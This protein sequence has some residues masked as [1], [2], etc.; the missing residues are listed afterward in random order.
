MD[1]APLVDTLRELVPGASFDV[2]P[3]IDMPTVYVDVDHLVDVCR[4]LRDAPSLQFAFLADV[5]AVD[6][7]PREP[8]FEVVYHL[9]CLGSAYAQSGGAAPARRLRLKVRVAGDRARLPSVTAVY[10]TA[11]WPEREVFDLFGLVFDGHADLRR[12]LM[13][14]DWEGHPLRKDYPVQIRK[15]TAA[16]SAMSM[17]PEEFAASIQA[18]RDRAVRQ[19]Q[20]GPFDA[21]RAGRDAETDAKGPGP[22]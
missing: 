13:T 5:T 21:L 8:R 17:T 18:A 19:A 20:A 15:D 9:A 2:V 4:A 22:E 10:P 14:D 6:Y 7:L 11:G 12:I 3:S 16:W 1:A